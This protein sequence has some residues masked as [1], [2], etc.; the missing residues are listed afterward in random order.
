[1]NFDIPQIILVS[2]YWPLATKDRFSSNTT[3][4]RS[5]RISPF[6]FQCPREAKCSWTKLSSFG[7][8]GMS[9]ICINV[10]AG[11][12]KPATW[13]L[14]IKTLPGGSDGKE[15]AYDAGDPGLIPGLRRY[16]GEG[17]GN[18]LQSS[19]LG[20]PMDRGAYWAAVHGIT[21]SWILL[22]N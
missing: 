15:S 14:K 10:I 6:F 5:H 8:R 16:P 12:C 4:W 18:P 9:I 17:N 19:C 13:F 2:W 20:N 22:S 11:G 21:K 3:F 1:M 7:W